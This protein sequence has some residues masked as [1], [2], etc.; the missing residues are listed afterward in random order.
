MNNINNEIFREYDIRGIADR[1][2][3]DE[4]VKLIG[5]AYGTLIG[6]EST[7][8]VGCDVRLSSP[9]IKKAL[10]N[11]ILSTGV[12]VIDIGTVPTPVLYFSVYRLSTDGGIMITGSH[13]PIEYNG[14]KMLKGTK[15]IYGEEIQ[16][17][18]AII[19]KG[20]FSEGK[21]E[22]KESE[23]ISRYIDTIMKGASINK[24]LKVVIDPGNGT[25]GPIV[26]SLFDSFGIEYK[27][28]NCE[29]DGHFPAHLPDPTVPRYMEELKRT[30]IE[31]KA[32]VGIGF[33][34][35][36]DR[37]GV[38]D[39]KGEMVYGDKLLGV[40]AKE[41]LGNKPGSTIIFD[42]K[43]SRGLKEAVEKFGGKPL[44]WKTGH[45]LIKAKMQ[46]VSSPLAGEMSGHMFFA[47]E[48]FGYDDAIYAAMRLLRII[49]NSNKTFSEIQS[50]IPYY[51]STPEIRVE[52][53]DEKKFQL[54]K[55]LSD[56]F[57]KNY[58][59]IT[60]D[61]VRIE[62][63]NGWGLIRASNTQPVLV[64]RFEAKTEEELGK[65]RE[66]IYS[67]L[68]EYDFVKL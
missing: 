39:N 17:L 29:P 43:C 37:I 36:S 15:T 22:V 34:G 49:S 53:P 67:K 66:I 64:L 13:N 33:D 10:I 32:D 51:F 18:K 54:V 25:A 31:E 35:D 42:V 16:K 30:V 11:G 6:N 41:V 52:C 19:E 26:S 58:D 55:E 50:E 9:R 40:Y 14:F 47:D 1:D 59:T 60:I 12:N 8:A 23:M 38:I 27:C 28:I 57:S 7:V 24:T 65:I 48:Y 68:K 3:T 62:F 21:A 56:Y 4:V 2:L 20:V 46:E 63:E 45:S 5:K 44:M 61:G